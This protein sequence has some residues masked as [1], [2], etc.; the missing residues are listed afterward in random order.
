MARS[1]DLFMQDREADI[2]NSE[3]PFF[4]EPKTSKVNPFDI[5]ADNFTEQMEQY[6]DGNIDALETAIKM[7]QEYER[8]EIQMNLRKT[9]MDE[10]K[11]S[12]E[13]ESSKYPEAYKGYKVVIQ[14]RATPSY[15]HIPEWLELENKKKAIE[16]KAKLGLQMKLKGIP[17]V[18]A[19]TGEEI[20]L[21][22]ISTTSF[23]K[24]DKLKK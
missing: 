8:L 1:K 16:E 5:L 17:N 13:N 10:N 24:F 21:P 4:N 9:W 11:E 22:I 19:E 14:T 2:F 20:I 3:N 12:I 15:K 6:E 23:V 7:R 18:D